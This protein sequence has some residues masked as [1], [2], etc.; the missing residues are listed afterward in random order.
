MVDAQVL[1]AVNMISNE[2]ELLTWK[3]YRRTRL[4]LLALFIGWIPIISIANHLQARFHL[5]LA[6]PVLIAIVWIAA[7]YVQGWRLASWPCPYCGK[8]FRGL[9]PFLPKRC[10]NCQRSR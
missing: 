5:S 1:G 2:S 8:S 9:L 3:S 4:I 7:I 10:R 6:F